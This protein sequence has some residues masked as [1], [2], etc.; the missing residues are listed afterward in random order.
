MNIKD[1]IEDKEA[2]IIGLYG[3]TDAE[4]IKTFDQQIM[5]MIGDKKTK[6]YIFLTSAGGSLL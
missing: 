3:K 2:H 6:A 5:K 1:I 4:M